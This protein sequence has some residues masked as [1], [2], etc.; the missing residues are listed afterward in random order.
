MSE[1]E[2]VHAAYHSHHPTNGEIPNG[3]S[4]DKLT[5][6]T[7]RWC[8]WRWR[9]MADAMR[10]RHVSYSGWCLHDW[11]RRAAS[12]YI[13]FTLQLQTVFPIITGVINNTKAQYTPPTQL[14]CRVALRR[15][16]VLNSQLVGDSLDKSEQ[17]CRQRSQQDKP[18]THRRRNSTVELS[19][20]GGVYWIRN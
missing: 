15:R 7:S 11:S 1:P 4:T 18:N 3:K 2:F 5:V 10:H 9:W 19:C 16:C 17:I 6:T 8:W 20:V 14:N 12:G 13:S